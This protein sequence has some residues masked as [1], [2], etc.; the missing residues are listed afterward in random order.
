MLV[1]SVTLGMAIPP[2]DNSTTKNIPIK[3][4]IVVAMAGIDDVG[5]VALWNGN[6]SSTVL[7]TSWETGVAGRGSKDIS[8]KLTKGTNYIVFV[9]FNKIYAGTGWFSGGKWSYEFGIYKNQKLL[10]SHNDYEAD[11][12]PGVKYW[13]VFKANVSS[14]GKVILTDKVGDKELN[15]LRL[16]IGELEQKLLRSNP[17]ST[18]F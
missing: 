5:L 4:S 15:L 8:S 18:P 17:I 10:W 1:L 7:T 16:G 14:D 12:T 11:N 13:K 2:P 3:D 6:G 9:L